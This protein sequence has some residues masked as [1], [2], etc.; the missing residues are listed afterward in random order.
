MATIASSIKLLLILAEIKTVSFH[1]NDDIYASEQSFSDELFEQ[2]SASKL[3]TKVTHASATLASRKIADIKAEI[4]L[5]KKL[6]AETKS[7]KCD[8]GLDDCGEYT[9]I[10]YQYATL[11]ESAGFE[12]DDSCSDSAGYRS[13][14]WLFKES[15]KYE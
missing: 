9:G 15:L 12:I 13:I 7:I 3:F 4:D 2:L 10:M 1:A 14:A 11:F 8:L 5:V 6:L